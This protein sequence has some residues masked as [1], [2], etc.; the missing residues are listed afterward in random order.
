MGA[1]RAGGRVTKRTDE[2][3]PGKW[4]TL[5]GVDGSFAPALPGVYVIL[6]NREAVYIGQT[7]NLR[8]R[9]MRH[10][11]R[12]GYARNVHTPWG[13]FPDDVG[14]KCKIKLSRKLGDWAMWEIR[15]LHKLK[16]RFNSVMIGKRVAA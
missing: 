6:F 9:L 16:P 11:I 10:N 7:N 12:Y 2:W 1:P 4:I 14:I 3:M 8:L 5:N 13:S 15:L